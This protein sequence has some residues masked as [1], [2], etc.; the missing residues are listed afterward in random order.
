MVV[1]STDKRTSQLQSVR[2]TVRGRKCLRLSV[3]IEMI[4]RSVSLT[5]HKDV[6]TRVCGWGYNACHAMSAVSTTGVE[7]VSVVSEQHVA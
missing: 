1:K 7:A 2:M 5:R 6:V 4:S 3:Y